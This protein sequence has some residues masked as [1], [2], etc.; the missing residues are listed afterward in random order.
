VGQRN[1][2]YNLISLGLIPARARILGGIVVFVD[3]IKKSLSF[4]IHHKWHA[5]R[6]ELRFLARFL[7]LVD[8]AL[9]F[10]LLLGGVLWR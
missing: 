4:A 2:I 6:K 8:L 10:F 3:G 9:G 5:Y 7:E 1:L